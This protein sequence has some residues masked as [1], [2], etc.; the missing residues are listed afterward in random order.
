MST[1]T[2]SP[3][4]SVFKLV[5]RVQKEASTISHRQTMNFISYEIENTTLV[6]QAQTI[7]FAGFQRMSR[8]LPQVARYTRIAKNA[9]K[10]FVFGVMDITPPP[11]ENIRYVALS[12]DDQLTKEW[13]LVSFGEDYASA[14]ATEELTD[15]DDVD[16]KRQFK[17]IWTF[18]RDLVSILNDW[19]LQEVGWRTDYTP[20]LQHPERQLHYV[21]QII[22]RMQERERKLTI[23]GDTVRAKEVSIIIREKLYQSLTMFQKAR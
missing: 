1:Q 12:P 2:I 5:E 17:S 11:I 6:D 18:D 14:L 21:S 16:Q 8:F 7:V 10:V 13:F 15:I 9:S 4:F 19:L 22:A 20:D 3:E 23:K